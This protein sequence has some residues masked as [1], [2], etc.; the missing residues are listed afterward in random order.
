MGTSPAEERE[1][2]SFSSYQRKQQD[3]IKEDPLYA[4]CV[5]SSKVLSWPAFVLVG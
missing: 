2:P 3:K 5:R 4:I 1:G